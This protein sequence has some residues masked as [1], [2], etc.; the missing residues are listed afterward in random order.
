MTACSALGSVRVQWFLWEL[1][2]T[3]AFSGV[4]RALAPGRLTSE[5]IRA[6]MLEVL[7]ATCTRRVE[8]GA[9]FREVLWATPASRTEISKKI[10]LRPTRDFRASP[11]L[12]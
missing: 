10:S 6:T 12:K 11:D 9:R 5:E 4:W 2:G 3:V 8:N 7:W 1:L